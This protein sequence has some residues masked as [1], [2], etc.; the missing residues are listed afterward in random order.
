MS[1]IFNKETYVNKKII[2]KPGEEWE[3]LAKDLVGIYDNYKGDTRNYVSL[4][5]KAHI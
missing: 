4:M 2:N 1:D 3:Y 5:E